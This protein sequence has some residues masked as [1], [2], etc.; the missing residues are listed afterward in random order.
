MLTCD[1]LLRDKF[2]RL[3]RGAQSDA[4]TGLANRRALHHTLDA[5][6]QGTRPFAVLAL[7]I[8]HFKRVNDTF[9]HDAGDEVLKHLAAL[10]RQQSRQQ[11]LPCR[12][13]GEEFTLL[14]P[15]TGH[16]DARRIAGRIREAVEQA[17]TAH[18]GRL[19]L[20][21]GVVCRQTDSDQA[22]TLLKQADEQ[23]YKAKQ[24]GRN[25]VEVL[26]F[27]PAHPTSPAQR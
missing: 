10:L 12:V 15:D 17:D 20:S 1:Q 3:R 19:T 16:A 25:R 27:S 4:L 2:G 7:D 13:A 6:M 18:V 5:L 8:D 23:L 14:L 21:I 9:G 11:D 22:E 26:G 24:N